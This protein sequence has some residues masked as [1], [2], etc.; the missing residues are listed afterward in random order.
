MKMINLKT[1]SIVSAAVLCSHAAVAGT[2]QAG[3]SALVAP[4]PYRGN[5]DHVYPVPIINYD[6]DDFY[7][8]TLMAGYY[9]WNDDA[10]KLSVTASYFPLSFDPSD[11][12]DKRMK[13]LDKRHSTLMA[14]LAYSH[15][16]E[17]GTLRAS[18]NADTLDTSNGMTA[19]LGY[20]YA[21]KGSNWA[22]VPGFGVTWF[23]SNLT[24]YYYGVTKDESRRSG[25]HSYSPNDS[26]SPYVEVSAKYNFTPAWQGFVTGRYLRLSSEV[27]DSPIIENNWT[28]VLWTGVT[29][30]F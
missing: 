13:R 19:D 26:F 5:N 2:W 23:S 20:L 7:F 21:I 17:W 18:F 12:D 25:F 27:T 16:A 22:V 30:T 9:L 10:N 28:G 8:H 11:S 6:N 1:L 4:D 3:A 29:Y 15:N 24:Q 14:G